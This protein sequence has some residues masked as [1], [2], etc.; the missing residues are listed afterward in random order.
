MVQASLGRGGTK[1]GSKILREIKT[2]KLLDDEDLSKSDM[3]ILYNGYA[4]E[5]FSTPIFGRSLSFRRRSGDDNWI[6]SLTLMVLLA[7]LAGSS[8]LINFLVRKFQRRKRTN[9]YSPVEGASS[10]ES[11][12]VCD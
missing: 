10:V 4:G 9:S 7:G 2:W 3:Q 8:F 6:P 1:D 5:W 11:N 12:D